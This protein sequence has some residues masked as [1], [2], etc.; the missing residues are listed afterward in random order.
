M[1]TQPI[2]PEPPGLELFDRLRRDPHVLALV[3]SADE[4]VAQLGYTDHGRRHVHLVAVTAA[5]VLATLG[6]DEQA[7]D[8]AAVAGLLHDIGNVEGRDGHAAAG[9]TM[10]YRLLLERGVSQDDAATVRDAVANHDEVEGGEP[11]SPPS[12]ALIVA[13]K[14][15]IHR[16]RVRT[17]R[18]EDFDI[19]DRVNFAVTRSRLDVHA[20][21]KRIELKLA[22][23]KAVA[24]GE[25][26]TDLFAARFAMS[27]S[28][29]GFLGCSY[30]VD[31]NGKITP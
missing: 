31:I 2:T 24:T 25:E 16:S 20:V 27:G 10:A 26:V 6:H 15:D 7:C 13:D 30:V 17:R 12:A 23:E 21:R 14:A 1:A 18:P 3:T 4:A 11:V 19:H 28:A 5:R 8:L 29:A 9:A 22:V